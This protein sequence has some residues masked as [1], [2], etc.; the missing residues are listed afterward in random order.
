[1]FVRGEAQAE[2]SLTLAR[3]DPPGPVRGKSRLVNVHF[4]DLA[5]YG[6]SAHLALRWEAIGPGGELFPTL[7]ADIALS[8]AGEHATTLTLAG[9]YRLPLGNLGGEL[10][11]VVLRASPRLR[12]RC[13]STASLKRSLPPSR[14]LKRAAE[15]QMR[16]GSGR[17]PPTGPR[18]HPAWRRDLT[19]IR[20]AGRDRAVHHGRGQR[21]RG[22]GSRGSCRPGGAGRRRS[23]A[24]PHH[25]AGQ[26]RPAG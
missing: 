21:T 6:G 17:Q 20:S 26:S 16:V 22:H 14:R 12:S 24:R 9:V 8:P 13:S 23:A 10:D 1:M 19:P 7:D 11:Q 2:I 5:A 25:G 3:A 4:R 18:R 15:S